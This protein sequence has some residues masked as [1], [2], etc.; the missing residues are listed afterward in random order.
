MT[1]QHV[2][3]LIQPEEARESLKAVL[4]IAGSDSSGGAGIEADI[5]AITAHKAYALTCIT[6]LTAQNTRGIEAVVET[7]KEHL[8]KILHANFSDFVDGYK[9][10]HPLKVVKTGMLTESAVEVLSENLS[11]L[12]E[13]SVQ[14]VVDPVMVATSG[15]AL[16]DD[17]TMQLILKKII[18]S[19]Y[20][21]TPNYDEAIFLSGAELDDAEVARNFDTEATFVSFVTGLQK[22]LRCEN[23]LVKG[24][25]V[26]FI[27][28]KRDFGEDQENKTNREEKAEIYDVLYESKSDT[29][30]I[31]KS[32]RIPTDNSH[33]TGCTLASSIAANLAHGQPLAEA[34]ALS[35][36]YVHKGM[37][38]VQGPLGHGNG[39]LNHA[40]TT[41][42]NFLGVLRGEPWILGPEHDTFYNY[43]ITHPSILASW[44]RYTKHPFLGLLA[45]N[46]LPFDDFLYF[47]KQ[48]YYYLV[49]YAKVHG[50]AASVAPTC[51]QIQAQTAIIANIMAEIEKHLQ[52][53]A[54]RYNVDYS[55]ADLDAEL[56]PG[57][58]CVAYCEYLNK[59]GREQD[60]L[61]IK[62]AVAPCLHGYAEAGLY[63]LAIRANFDGN[64]NKLETQEQS[65]VYSAWLDDYASDWYRTA[66]EDGI[67]LLDQ[68]LL[69]EPVSELRKEE[70]RT[71]FRD[72]VDLE[73]AFWDEVVDRSKE[74]K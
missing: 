43:F 2:I 5:K 72:V 10:L 52:K 12:Q 65:D 46:N 1:T 47:L 50:H 6:A 20:L 17:A 30:T 74:R 18:P 38:T 39:P 62:V 45:T 31:F 35:V 8:R 48:D 57:P 61:A 54:A 37:V 73:I 70:L 36:H 53:L 63:G 60:F 58:A 16:V 19:S 56:Q 68:L 23:L 22:K 42:T 41:S 14:L 66:H 4:T 21:C 29:V 7:P 71:M 3:E 25:H 44:E 51:D 64:L 40:V 11:Y 49:N 32:P 59:I 69:S 26:P 67:Q 28:G 24:G 13:N 34:V 15:K 55:K 9:G 27:G 33:G